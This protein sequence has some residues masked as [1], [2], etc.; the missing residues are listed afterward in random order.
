MDRTLKRQLIAACKVDR[1]V[2]PQDST[3]YF[4]FDRRDL[5]GVPWRVGIR[6]VIDLASEPVAVLTTGQPGSGKSTEL[7]GLEN[8]LRGLGY[9]VFR[10]EAGDWIRDDEPIRTRSLLLALAL[11]L[12][13]KGSPDDAQGWAREYARR[14][15]SHF[16]LNWS[17]KVP[18]P[19]G[20]LS[21]GAD[22]TSKDTLFQELARHLESVRGLRDQVF[23]LLRQAQR[24]L[25]QEQNKRIVIILDGVEKRATGDLFGREKREEYRNRWFGAFL[26]EARDLKAP[27]HVVY[28]VPAFMVR[29]SAQ[30]AAQFGQELHFLPMVRTFERSRGP[31][32]PL[33]LHQPGLVALCE[34][35]FKRVPREH[36]DSQTVAGWLAAHC[37]GYMRDLLRLTSECI[38]LLGNNSRVTREIADR[39]IEKIRRTY[40]DGFEVEDEHLLIQTHRRGELPL[41]QDNEDR[42]DALLQGYQILR[43][44]N[45]DEWY[46]VHPLLWPRLGLPGLVWEDVEAA[47]R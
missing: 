44:H 3:K 21:L 26:T 16:N 18:T 33:R 35:L 42:I 30:L 31:E 7:W 15:T 2:D 1:P 36:F 10:V 46:G 12:Y 32:V 43:Y 5:R 29:R 14:F 38:Y 6:N 24:D 28:T 13:P 37:G 45:G 34:A 40:L 23:E 8:D 27:V 11:A 4:D 39:A 19:V 41:D 22:A 9:E 20:E 25:E 17:A 47:C